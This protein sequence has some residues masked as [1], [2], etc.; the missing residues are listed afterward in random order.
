M[1]ELLDDFTTDPF[2]SRWTNHLQAVAWDSGAGELDVTHTGA[3]TLSEYVAATTGSLNHEVQITTTTFAGETEV[4][5]VA[6]RIAGGTPEGYAVD[7]RHGSNVIRVLLYSGGTYTEL[8]TFSW[9]ITSGNFVTLRAAFTTSG[10]DVVIDVWRQEH[11]SSK[12]SDPGWIGVDGTPDHTYTHTSGL[13]GGTYD[14]VGIGGDLA[15]STD[16]DTQT[17][18]WKARNITDRGGGNSLNVRSIGEPVIGG[19]IF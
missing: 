9:T 18:Y 11:T 6:G 16:Y 17:D 10:S 8:T 15:L 5:G 1:A 14:G 7:M 19:S 2:A 3:R 4:V 12:P 13:T